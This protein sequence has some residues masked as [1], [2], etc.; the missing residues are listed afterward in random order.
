M[1]R[2]LGQID[3]HAN[4]SL[5]RHPLRVPDDPVV[6]ECVSV[7]MVVEVGWETARLVVLVVVWKVAALATAATEKERMVETL[8]VGVVQEGIAE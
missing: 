8:E 3:A 2:T 1:Q 4:A 6:E 7:V 5:T